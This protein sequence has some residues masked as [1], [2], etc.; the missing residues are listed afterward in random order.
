MFSASLD[1]FLLSFTLS[2][3]AVLA[4]LLFLPQGLCTYPLCLEKSS[5]RN[6]RGSPPHLSEGP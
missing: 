3:Q 2:A 1:S 4:S 5:L 6:P